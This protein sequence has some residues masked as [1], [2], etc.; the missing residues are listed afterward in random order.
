MIGGHGMGG[1]RMVGRGFM[2]GQPEDDA[3]P[4]PIRRAT[5]VRVAGLFGPYRARLA[6]VT[7][8]VL[9]SAG[10]GVVAPLL[11]RRVIDVV[12][13]ARDM[14]HLTFLVLLM[15]G[16]T[17]VAGGLNLLQAYINTN[18]GLHVMQD[19]RE[20]VYRHLQRQ[21]L[22]F[23][24]R[25][26]TGDIQ[27]RLTNDITGTQSVLT[28]TASM[29]VSNL[30]VV[31]SSVAAMLVISWQLSLVGLGMMP[32][33]LYFMIRV[34][35]RRR[36]LTRDAQRSVAE[37]TARTGETLSVSGVIVAKT[38][39]REREHLEQF[40][41][42]SRRLTRISIRQQ[43]TGR[44]FF[45]IVQTFFGLAPAA[46]WWLGGWLLADGN[47][48]V[49][50]GSLVAFTTLQTRLLFPLAGLMTRSVEVTS[51]LALFD[52]IFE[53]LDEVPEI[54]DPPNPVRIHRPTA[55][56]EVRFDHVAFQY[57]GRHNPEGEA[58]EAFSLEDV[59]FTA[60]PGKM[61]AIVGP[62]G[63]GKTTVGYLIS[64]L[65]DVD[66]GAVLIDGVNVRDLALEDLNRLVGV[67]SQDPFLFHASVA[68]NLRYGKPDA[69]REEMEEA[70]RT[71]QIGDTIKA[72]SE[73]YE[74]LVGERGYRMSGGE[75]Q[76]VA[77]ARVLLADPGILLLD[78]AT[79]SLDTLSERLIQKG[80][81]SLMTGRTTIAIAHRL[82]TV[83][84]ADQIVV[85]DRGRIVG[86]GR[87]SEL[88][89]R[90]PL[91][92]RLYEEQF[93]AAPDPLPATGS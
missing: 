69:T 93:I 47:T 66:D 28:D 33:F 10:L 37:L 84:A 79:S 38:F 62:S 65:Y 77:I 74:T 90:S 81:A 76:R 17:A 73:G 52:R 57:R 92:R 32:L 25:T 27:S 48:A 86:R 63:S 24:T 6:L 30:A 75:R 60:E 89:E 41:E 53:Y 56:G 88:I 67:V 80:L 50:V 21:T 49:T 82:S 2:R 14:D 46:I 9:A 20:N 11:I 34:G 15:V 5:L 22:R 40:E 23:F 39:A 71:A 1:G 16:A 13:P 8:L 18:I 29:I 31:I 3:P 54:E 58:E 35:N 70:A 26:R 91:Y 55:K 83:I 4:R 78:E 72:L 68:D 12:L 36:R 19:V 61:T 87:H 51:S 7:A 45:V 64:R 44:G 42:N 43:M 59:D 85:M